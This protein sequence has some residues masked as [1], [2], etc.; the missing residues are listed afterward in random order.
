MKKVLLTV[1]MLAVLLL[2]G[3]RAVNAYLDDGS[4]QTGPVELTDKV[5][6]LDIE[7]ASGAVE[8]KYGE[9]V[10]VTETAN[11]AL[12]ENTSLQW[13][14]DGTTLR[15]R[16]CKAGGLVSGTLNLNKTL[17]VTIPENTELTELYISSASADVTTAA[18]A[19]Q[20]ANIDAASGAV[21]T[22]LIGCGKA[23]IGTASGA[24]TATL[25]GCKD[26]KIVT[27]SGKVK[28]SLTDCETVSLETASGDI[29]AVLTGCGTA[30]IDTASGKQTLAVTDLLRE[31]SVDTASGDVTLTLP[32]TL[33]FTAEVDTA[34]G[35]FESELPVSMSGGRYV[36]GDGAA[37]LDLETASGDVHITRAK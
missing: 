35:K 17:T 1:F 26:T 21:R 14:L 16:F 6:N 33:G 3:C 4:Y 2:S 11:R 19:A 23:E 25:R 34:S 31:L 9:G 12:D 20:T 36:C 29:G 32:E 24:V 7:W 28:A 8:V 30:E 10:T 18:I 5:E 22:E 37:A 15:I 27:A 13:Y